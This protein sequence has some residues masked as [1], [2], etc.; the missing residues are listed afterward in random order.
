ML[1]TFISAIRHFLYSG[2]F[3]LPQGA[4]VGF[5]T[6]D[7]VL[8]FYNLSPELEQF[9]MMVIA[10]NEDVY[11]PLQRGLC[12][13]PIASRSLIESL[14]DSLPSLFMN[15]RTVEAALGSACEAAYQAL[16]KNM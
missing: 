5:M 1:F 14:L 7:K 10:D 16:V 4:T 12:V 11:C 15:N 2:Q 8:H 3:K 9:Q 6:F 13:D